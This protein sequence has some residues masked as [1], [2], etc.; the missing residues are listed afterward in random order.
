MK[1][2]NKRNWIIVRNKSVY[3]LLTDGLIY[4]EKDIKTIRLLMLIIFVAV[5]KINRCK[6]K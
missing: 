6:S 3:Y 2:W 1:Q 4:T 5:Y